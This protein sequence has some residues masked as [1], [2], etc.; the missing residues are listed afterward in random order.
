M[1]LLH[2]PAIQT[3]MGSQAG[4][5]LSKKLGTAVS[6]GRI[7]LG[8]FNRIV[9]DD[10]TIYDQQQQKMLH[11]S[12]LAGK[13]DVLP[14]VF[15]GKVRVSSTQLFGLEADFYKKTATA[16]PNFQFALD[17]LASKDTLSHTPLDIQIQ[18]LVIRHGKVRY[19]QWDAP[20]T[21]HQFNLKH[22]DLTE[23]STHIN[24]YT[25]TDDSLAVK[26][27][28][29]IQGKI[30]IRHS[31]THLPN[32]CRQKPQPT[33]QLCPAITGYPHQ[34]PQCYRFL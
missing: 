33:Q 32:S 31:F 8:F 5:F 21:P 6:V 16:K 17:S 2:I 20:K 11:A 13:I 3:F 1:V 22:L 26:V 24:L 12:R 10:I 27:K 34:Y 9:I 29:G 18:S 14:L 23:L 28:N 15:D 7:N 19:N 4:N 25:L 30:W